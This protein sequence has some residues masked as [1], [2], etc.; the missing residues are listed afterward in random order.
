[1]KLNRTT[2]VLPL[3]GLLVVAGAGAVLATG[4]PAPAA[5]DTTVVPAAESPSASPAT[6]TKTTPKD[7]A[8]TDVLDDLVAKGTINESQKQAIL[9][10][11]TAERTARREAR[12]ATREQL[13]TFLEDGVITQEEF[14]QLPEDSRFRQLED[15]LGNGG[16]TTDELK[17]LGRG[18]GMGRGGH[19]HG[20]NV[21]PDGTSP[22]AP[23]S[24]STSS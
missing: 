11:L 2:L 12:Q 9:D 4:A 15:L 8:L 13:R 7:T 19:G 22:D 5:T 16:I 18:F 17:A 3:A 10:G 14:D 23:A 6:D 1:M 24:P 21:A 20:W